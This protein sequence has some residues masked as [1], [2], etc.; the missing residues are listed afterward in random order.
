MKTY[1]YDES[2]EVLD[3]ATP[4]TNIAEILA[5]CK[6]VDDE[7][8]VTEMNM[9]IQTAHVIVCENLDGYSISTARLTLVE[10]YLA[11]HFAAVTYTPTSFEAAGKVQESFSTKVALGFDLTR[12]GQQ[13]LRLDPTGNLRRMDEAKI[14]KAT[15]S[16]LGVTMEEREA[17]DAN[18]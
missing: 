15:I 16:W 4:L 9:F 7:T 17:I 2:T 13:A 1:T 12:Y 14:K 10:R 18:S 6:E 8:P 11:A 5:I 3:E